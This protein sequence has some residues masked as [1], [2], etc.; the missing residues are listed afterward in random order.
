MVPGFNHNVK[1]KGQV[2]HVQTEDSGVENPH[3]ITH[4]FLGGNIV[5]SQK[6]SYDALLNEPD[7][8]DKVKQIMQAQHKQM[9]RSLVSGAF[10]D[11]IVS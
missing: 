6:S 4:L 7:L 11:K 2:F 3:I 1:Y 10:D 5:K 8:I 9:L